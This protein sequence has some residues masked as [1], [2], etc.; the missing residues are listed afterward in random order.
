[1]RLG[2]EI[3]LIACVVYPSFVAIGYS[4]NNEWAAVMILLCNR[5]VFRSP[6]RC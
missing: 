5:G 3:G 6:A 1:M 2:I 4:L